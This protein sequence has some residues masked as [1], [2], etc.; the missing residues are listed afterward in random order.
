MADNFKCGENTRLSVDCIACQTIECPRKGYCSGTGDPH[1]TTFDGTH[2]DF[3]GL[4]AL[5]KLFLLVDRCVV[6]MSRGAREL[7]GGKVVSLGRVWNRFF[8]QEQTIRCLKN[9]CLYLKTTFS[10]FDKLSPEDA[11]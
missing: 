4:L 11:P 10:H 3:Q 6:S 9:I 2:Y 5:S 7:M 1:E 8:T